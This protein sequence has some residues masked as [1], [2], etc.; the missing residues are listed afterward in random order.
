MNFPK[1]TTKYNHTFIVLSLIA[2]WKVYHICV[3]E[4]VQVGMQ[5]VHLKAH[6]A[7]HHFEYSNHVGNQIFVTLWPVISEKT[8]NNRFKTVRSGHSYVGSALW[9]NGYFR[10]IRIKNLT[11]LKCSITSQCIPCTLGFVETFLHRQSFF[12]RIADCAKRRN[13]SSWTVFNCSKSV[14]WKRFT[15]TKICREN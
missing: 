2:T 14:N 11:I 13:I 15:S 4:L 9:R 10:C 1:L 12:L 3:F 7:T 8:T 5:H 6:S